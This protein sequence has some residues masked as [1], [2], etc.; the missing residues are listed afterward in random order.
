L[1]SVTA[2]RAV[3]T[4]WVGS[5]RKCFAVRNQYQHKLCIV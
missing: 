2:W 5:W 1:V 3:F 4:R